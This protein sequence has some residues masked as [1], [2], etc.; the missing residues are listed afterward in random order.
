MPDVESEEVK[1]L[2]E[3]IEKLKG[4]NAKAVT[5]LQSLCHAY[6]DLKKDYEERTKAHEEL[7]KK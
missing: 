6:M 3:E 1:R 7:I 2:K 5:D 4:V